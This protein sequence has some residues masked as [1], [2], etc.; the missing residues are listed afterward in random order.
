MQWLGGYAKTSTLALLTPPHLTSLHLH[1]TSPHSTSDIPADYPLA[2]SFQLQPEGKRKWQ[3]LSVFQGSNKLDT[4]LAEGS[5][6]LRAFVRDKHGATAETTFE[7]T[8][9]PT[10]VT[11]Y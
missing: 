9:Q 1:L 2:F 3:P 6:T 5:H 7:V 11:L 8:R 4:Q 10:T